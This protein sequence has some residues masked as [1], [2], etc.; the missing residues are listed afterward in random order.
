M[1]LS[2]NEIA[3]VAARHWTG[4]DLVTAIAV[5]LAE[6][7]GDT[8]AMGRSSA[9]DSNTGNRDHGLWQ[10][11][12]RWH[13]LRG[14]GT[15]GRLKLA[16]ARWR[17]PYVAARLA[18]EV[19]DETKAMG[20]DPWSAWAVYRSGSYK[21]YLPDALIAVKAP[22]APPRDLFAALGRLDEP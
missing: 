16:G 10:I 4:E 7:G 15:D 1:K 8:D 20:K 11:S 12:N 21:T 6:S 13:Q 22:W 19:Y 2:P 14:D 18:R 17:D 5:A 3:F 9:V